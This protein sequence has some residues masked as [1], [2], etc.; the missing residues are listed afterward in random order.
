M[1]MLQGDFATYSY[2]AQSEQFRVNT[3]EKR[4]LLCTSFSSLDALL[5]MAETIQ[6]WN[7]S[8]R[9]LI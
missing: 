3:D 7:K 5:I 1:C 9:F 6:F 2:F 8:L 4:N